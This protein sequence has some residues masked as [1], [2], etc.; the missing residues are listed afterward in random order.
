[1]NP[2][3]KPAYIP[4]HRPSIGQAEIDEV[5]S[6]LRSGWLTMGPRTFKFEK[7]FKQYVK[8]RHAL[9]VNSCTAGLHLALTALGVGHGDEVITT[10]LTFCAT[11]NA[12]LQTGA[13]PVLADVD[14]NGN[15]DPR[16]VLSR[17]SP[18]TRALLP[19]HLAG[20]PCD[21]D[22]L[23]KL[24]DSHGLLVVEDAAHAVGAWYAG[25]P[26]GHC[27][28]SASRHSDAVAFSFYATKNLT[29]GEGG[30]VTTAD[31]ELNA[32][33]RVLRLHGID[34]DA[35][36]RY[37]ESGDWY[38][39]VVDQGFKYN[40]TDLQAAIGIHQLRRLEEFIA[41]RSRYAGL[42]A[43]ELGGVGEVDLP[44]TGEPSRHAWHLYVL[45]LKLDH[46][47]IDRAAFIRE[48]RQRGIGSSVHFIPITLHPAYRG[49]AHSECPK[50][51]QLYQRI[52]SLPLYPAMTE[53]EVRYVA[54]SVKDVV[55]RH[56]NRTLVAMANHTR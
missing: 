43:E 21:M 27:D 37:A 52:V 47:D 50:A 40:M 30:M 42:Y 25:W 39:E 11:V 31:D 14:E 56:R 2:V 33:M 38:Y 20:L 19:V 46:L 44:A 45:R 3:N 32:R 41:V 8:A 48:L 54:A 18:R 23:W 4:F 15:I 24:A 28:G 1:M 5:V 12:I 34:R 51:E 6:T 36:N 7:K 53:E 16:S 26:I 13:E 10:A 55:H 17:I 22:A 29:T 9:A 35:W 49:L